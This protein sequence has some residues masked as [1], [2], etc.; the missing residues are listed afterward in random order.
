MWRLQP[1]CAP[2]PRSTRAPEGSSQPPQP[3]PAP[4]VTLQTQR[5]RIL[6]IGCTTYIT[7]I[8]TWRGNAEEPDHRHRLLLRAESKRPGGHR[9]AENRYELAALHSITS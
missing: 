1:S 4:R 5:S 8:N 2:P 3:G 7:S 6:L 9:A